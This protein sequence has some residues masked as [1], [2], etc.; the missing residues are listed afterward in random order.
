MVDYINECP[1]AFHATVPLTP[2]ASPGTGGTGTRG[3]GDL[4]FRGLVVP[5]TGG[6]GETR[7]NGHCTKYLH[8]QSNLNY[9]AVG[10]HH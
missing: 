10:L 1:S 3:T 6:T 4:G 9:W 5:G 2:Y 8:S 7:G